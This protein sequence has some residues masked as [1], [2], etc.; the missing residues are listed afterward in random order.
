LMFLRQ[1]SGR[2]IG[3]PWKRRCIEDGAVRL[4]D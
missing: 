3:L 2:E 4:A 1:L